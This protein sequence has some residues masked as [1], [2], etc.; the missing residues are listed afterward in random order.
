MPFD[1]RLRGA[2]ACGKAHGRV[3]GVTRKGVAIGVAAAV[4][5]AIVELDEQDDPTGM[6]I[7]DHEV[8]AFGAEFVE[9]G[10]PFRLGQ[11][12]GPSGVPRQLT[13]P[14]SCQHMFEEQFPQSK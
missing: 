14:H 12:F 3:S 6:R 13:A 2:F 11:P 5:A 10:P 1:T 4:V 7:L 8:D 9:G